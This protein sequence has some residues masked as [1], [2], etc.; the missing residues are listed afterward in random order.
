MIEQIKA[1]IFNKDS[2][3]YEIIACLMTVA[4]KNGVLYPK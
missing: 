4:S 2:E 1:I 3:Q